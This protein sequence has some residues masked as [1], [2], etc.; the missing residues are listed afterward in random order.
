[1]YKEEFIEKGIVEKV[2][3]GFAVIR[4]NETGNCDEC[5]AKLICKSNNDNSR[6][7][8]A[9]NLNGVQPGYSVNISIPG[10]GLSVAAIFVYGIP[11]VLLMLGILIGMQL[12]I[13]SPELWSSLLG[14]SL[15]ALY[16][17]FIKSFSITRI[18]KLIPSAKIISY[19]SN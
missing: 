6:I 11:L 4:L 7:I 2:E 18:N 17:L 5:S 16:Y 9:V 14:I 1:M 15:A 10:K 12:F 13:N 19:S 3:D 8:T